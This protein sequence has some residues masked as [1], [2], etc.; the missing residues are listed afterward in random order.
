MGDMDE[1]T[2]VETPAAPV[3]PGMEPETTEE[4]SADDGH[5]HDADET[6]MDTP[7]AGM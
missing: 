3:V 6:P 1:T 2:P 5:D 7:A 4:H